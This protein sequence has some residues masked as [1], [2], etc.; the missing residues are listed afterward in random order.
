MWIEGEA[1][2]TLLALRPLQVGDRIKFRVSES[3]TSD[4]EE[5]AKSWPDR[6]PREAE[7]VSIEQ[8]PNVGCPCGGCDQ[9][10]FAIDVNDG[11]EITAWWSPE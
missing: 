8:F 1:L 4:D 11:D 6:E 5:L 2:K 10:E 3:R 9:V 7:V